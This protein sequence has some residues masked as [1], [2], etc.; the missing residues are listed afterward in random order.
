MVAS[1]GRTFVDDGCVDAYRLRLL[2]HALI[3]T[4][5]LWEAALLAGVPSPDVRDVDAMAEVARH[6][7]R[8]GPSW[9]LVKGGHLPGVES[10]VGGSGARPT[11]PTC[12]STVRTSSSSAVRG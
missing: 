1:T 4:P 12:S 8:F 9:V 10:R 6:I 2:P 7:H 3:V 5:N 11:W